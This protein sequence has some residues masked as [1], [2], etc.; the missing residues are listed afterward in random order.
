MASPEQHL[1]KCHKLL[2]TS[3]M[4]SFTVINKTTKI[5][6]NKVGNG[7][8]RN[9]PFQQKTLQTK[10]RRDTFAFSGLIFPLA[11]QLKHMGEM[12]CWFCAN[13][14]QQITLHNFQPIFFPF[15]VT[16]KWSNLN[17]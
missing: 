6:E 15:G 14:N 4:L 5:A 11:F 7:K 2:H 17:A 10:K 9:V 13:F 3:V 1:M 16:I 12:T 8:E